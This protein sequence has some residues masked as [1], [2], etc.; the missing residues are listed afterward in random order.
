MRLTAFGELTVYDTSLRL[1]VYL[2]LWP[3]RV[4][5]HAG[6]KKGCKALGVTTNGKTAEIESLPA[7]IRTLDAYHAE[8][9]LCIFKDRFAGAGG[10]LKAGEPMGRS[11]C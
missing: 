2:D 6:T 4:Y 7:A 8:K 11:K 1:G 3:K 5:L 9:F 10:T